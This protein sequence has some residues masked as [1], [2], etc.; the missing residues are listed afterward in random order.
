MKPFRGHGFSFPSL[1]VPL[2]LPLACRN[3]YQTMLCTLAASLIQL[4]FLGPL[5]SNSRC[6]L[7]KDN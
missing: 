3:F 4:T 5:F 6:R 2:L 7:R 1:P